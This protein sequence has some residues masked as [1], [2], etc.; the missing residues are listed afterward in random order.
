MTDIATTAEWRRLAELSRA[1]ERP[2]MRALFAADPDRARRYAVEAAGIYFDFSKNR[3]DEG[4]LSALLA[5]SAAAGLDRA[6]ARMFAGEKINTTEN[7]AVLHVA[8]R[9]FS[10]AAYPVEE[11]DAARLAAAERVRMKDFSSRV[12]AGAWKGWTGK[13]LDT[14]VNIG[15]GGSD[16]GPQ[17]AVEA[18]RPYWIE[19]RRAFFVSNVDGQHLADTLRQV[20]PERT[21]F[22]VASK[23]FTTQETMSNAQSARDWLLANGAGAGDVAKHFVALST[24]AGAVKEFGIDTDNMFAFWDW[25]GG[26]YSLWG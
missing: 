1:P 11:G 17:M 2:S 10:G 21:L 23:T 3:L 20:D 12:H 5:L 22:I 9:D 8:L 4:V 19:G 25:V 6:R 15:I 7:R 13:P 16:L 26:R 24:N 18:L 14:V